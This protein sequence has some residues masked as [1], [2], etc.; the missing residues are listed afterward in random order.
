MIKFSVR[1]ERYYRSKWSECT[2]I[3]DKTGTIAKLEVIT[4]NEAPLIATQP[5]EAEPLHQGFD[6]DPVRHNL[7]IEGLLCFLGKKNLSFKVQSAKCPWRTFSY[8]T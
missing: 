3:N 4:G 8:S 1:S 5:S 2:G 6:Q 7:K